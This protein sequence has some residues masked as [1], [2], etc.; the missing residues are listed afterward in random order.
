M[1]CCGSQITSTAAEPPPPAPR[2]AVADAF[3][4]ILLSEIFKPLA[5]ALGPVGDVVVGSVTQELFMKAPR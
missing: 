2:P 5:A 3:G 1:K 4:A